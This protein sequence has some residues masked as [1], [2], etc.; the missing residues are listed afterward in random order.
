MEPIPSEEELILSCNRV[1]K[2][3]FPNEKE[4][5]KIRLYYNKK[6]IKKYIFQKNN[7]LGIKV[8]NG[9]IYYYQKDFPTLPFKEQNFIAR[10]N[11]IDTKIQIKMAEASGQI[12]MDTLYKV[13]KDKYR[14][15]AD[16]IFQCRKYRAK[17]AVA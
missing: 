9:R 17:E 10:I 7:T 5:A 12:V 11:Y 1:I 14:N 16:T 15:F 2:K 3:Y 8:I 6:T 13:L 4:K